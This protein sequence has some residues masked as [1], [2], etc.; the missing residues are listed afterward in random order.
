MC[1]ELDAL[2]PHLPEDRVIPVLA[3]GAGAERLTLKSADGTAFAVALAEC[4][5][6]IGG[7]AVIILPDVRGL[8]RFYVD[9]AERF[10]TAGYHALSADWPRQTARERPMLGACIGPTRGTRGSITW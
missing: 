7:T 3:G 6:P 1:F 5:E 2:P 4:P 10:V 9:L 8:Y